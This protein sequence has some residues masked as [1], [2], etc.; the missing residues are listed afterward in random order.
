MK[1][2]YGKGSCALAIHIIIKEMDL[3]CEFEAVDLKTKQTAHGI[4]FPTINPKNM[5]PALQLN[6]QEILTEASIILQYLADTHKAESLLPIFG[7]LRYRALEWLNYVST[8][9]HKNCSPLFNPNIPEAVKQDVFRPL[10]KNKLTYVNQ[11]L[12][13][14]QFLLDNQFTLAD[15]YLFVVLRW[16]PAFKIDRAEF[17]ALQR[18]FTHLLA[19]PAIMLALKEEGL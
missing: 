7:M 1:L 16:L 2:Y 15:S 12:T 5:V 10:L 8:D 14:R 11:H 3:P 18:Y 4:S 19:R 6:N 13:N 9:L 17:P